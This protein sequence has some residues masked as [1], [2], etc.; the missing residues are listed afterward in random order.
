[1]QSFRR[2]IQIKVSRGRLCRYVSGFTALLINCPTARM[3]QVVCSIIGRN[4][5]IM[6]VVYWSYIIISCRRAIWCFRIWCVRQLLVLLWFTIYVPYCALTYSTALYSRISTIK[7]AFVCVVITHGAN[8]TKY[9]CWVKT[10]ASRNCAFSPIAVE[11]YRRGNCGSNYLTM[12]VNI[13]KKF[14]CPTNVQMHFVSMKTC[15]R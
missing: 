14:T 6:D 15:I 1:M 10:P 4:S 3:L 13:L 5:G 9:M 2:K 12:R 7:P 11:F 8:M